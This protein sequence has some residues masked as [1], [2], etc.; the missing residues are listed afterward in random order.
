MEA[1]DSFA[2]AGKTNKSMTPKFNLDKQFEA[3]I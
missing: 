2:S 3:V 1:S